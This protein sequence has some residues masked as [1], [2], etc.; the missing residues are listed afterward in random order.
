MSFIQ[1]NTDCLIP[2]SEIKSIDISDIENQTVYVWVSPN[3]RHV[4][5]GFYAIEAVMKVKPSAL[6]GNPH[7]KWKKGAWAIHN[8]VIHP[9]MQLMV[10]AG[11]TKAAIELH[12]RQTPAPI[13]YRHD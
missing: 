7:L 2:V 3:L 11:Y 12:D 6:E 1:T 10:W 9:V 8:L 4:I 5:T 13:G